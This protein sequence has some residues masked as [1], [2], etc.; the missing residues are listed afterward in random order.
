MNLYIIISRVI[1]TGE[2]SGLI[3]FEIL[4]ADYLINDKWI[5]PMLFFLLKCSF[6]DHLMIIWWLSD[7]HEL[8]CVEYLMI[9]CWLLS[10]YY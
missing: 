7:D 8:F 3:P 10:D 9:I 6:A 5:T 2:K 1:E 4:L